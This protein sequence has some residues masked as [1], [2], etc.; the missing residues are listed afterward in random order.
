MAGAADART[1]LDGLSFPDR[2][3]YSG[4]P[5]FLAPSVGFNRTLDRLGL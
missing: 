3:Y 1:A 4:K 5:W 2:R